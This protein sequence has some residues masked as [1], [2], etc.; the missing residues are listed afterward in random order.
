MI[1]DTLNQIWTGILKFSETFVTPNW[2]ELIGLLPI[3]LLIGVVG[4]IVTLDHVA[5]R[6]EKLALRETGA[7]AVDMES[8]WLA[9]SAG[10]RPVAVVRAVVD[11]ADRR[12]L[13]PRTIPAGIAGLRALRRAAPCL[14]QWSEVMSRS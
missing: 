13:D 6:A 5:S 7:L 11:R 3:L 10:E 9:R 2:G 12:L 4:P 14:G 1:I 8:Y